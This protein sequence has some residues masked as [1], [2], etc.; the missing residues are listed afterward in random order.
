MFIW[1]VYPSSGYGF[2]H[3]IKYLFNEKNIK[4]TIYVF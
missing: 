3:K 4:S 1:F 2:K